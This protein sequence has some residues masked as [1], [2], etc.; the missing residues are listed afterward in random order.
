VS[1]LH[2]FTDWRF[3]LREIAA[4]A[5]L[6]FGIV[7]RVALALWFF[8]LGCWWLHSNAVLELLAQRALID[9]LAHKCGPPRGFMVPDVP[10]VVLAFPGELMLVGG[11]ALL[12][13]ALR[14]FAP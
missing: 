6:G 9:F 14:R 13:G 7:W 3:R 11:V 8:G 2:G 4:G 12:A 10:W 5:H 1:E